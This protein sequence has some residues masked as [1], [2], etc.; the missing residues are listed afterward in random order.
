MTMNAVSDIRTVG[1]MDTFYED[2]K[3]VHRRP[4]WQ[5]QGTSKKPTLS[6]LWKYRDFRPL[7]FRAVGGERRTSEDRRRLRCAA[8]ARKTGP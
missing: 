1:T 2:V 8:R 5:T 7:L 6:Y 3:R 4:L